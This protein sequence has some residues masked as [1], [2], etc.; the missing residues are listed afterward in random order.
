MPQ[1][2]RLAQ[3]WFLLLVLTLFAL[4]VIWPETAS[5]GPWDDL[6]K[7]AQ[8]MAAQAVKQALD[9]AE[10]SDGDLETAKQTSPVKESPPAVEKAEPTITSAPPAPTS[11]PPPAAATASSTPP[12]PAAAKPAVTTPAAGTAAAANPASGRNLTTVPYL[13]L[14]LKYQPAAVGDDQLLQLTQRQVDSDQR[15]YGQAAGVHSPVNKL[16]NARKDLQD[17]IQKLQQAET[18]G[19]KY[20]AQGNVDFFK[21]TVEKLERELAQSMRG[22]VFDRAEVENRDAAFA[23]QELASKYRRHL[24][25]LAAGLPDKYTL[26][27]RV[28]ARFYTYDFDHGI[29]YNH[30]NSWL[31]CNPDAGEPCLPKGS[32]TK[33]MGTHFFITGGNQA[34]WN[35][36][37]RLPEFKGYFV[38]R[39]P[40]APR[41]DPL[42]PNPYGYPITLHAG[43]VQAPSLVVLDRNIALPALKMDTASAEAIKGPPPLTKAEM[44]AGKVRIPDSQRLVRSILYLTIQDVPKQKTQLQIIKV[45]LDKLEIFSP[46][47]KLLLA[48]N[49]DD[50]ASSAELLAQAGAQE[51]AAA[52]GAKDAVAAQESRLDILG[53]K[54]GM[55]LAEAEAIVRA[56]MKPTSE[57]RYERDREF[58]PFG[59]EPF[60]RSTVYI[61]MEGTPTGDFQYWKT[62]TPKEVIGLTVETG[63]DGKDHVFGIYRF[64]NTPKNADLDAIGDSLRKKY[65]KPEFQQGYSAR[66]GNSKCQM[67]VKRSPGKGE[68]RAGKD[69]PDESGFWQRIYS[70][71]GTTQTRWKNLPKQNVFEHCGPGMSALWSER[72][73]EVSL[74]DLKAYF[75]RFEE[76]FI[77][78]SKNEKKAVELEL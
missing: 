51:A 2:K 49:A 8:D 19:A 20:T 77:V 26:E 69:I 27:F 21:Q 17:A 52:Q 59:A 56:R 24:E 35:K 63:A 23:A 53:I 18:Q 5:A 74:A 39:P 13:L 33:G 61:R 44:Q 68:L 57:F 12:A 71:I 45:G 70:S 28:P 75:S 9:D 3:P 78:G 32:K 47:Q 67:G 60:A 65:G 62:V 73:L 4:S 76:L 30:G 43:G 36:N 42:N 38:V 22:V 25:K 58:A 29:L 11:T 10:E 7:K 64:L 16:K 55:S 1:P 54:L 31:P 46:E 34:R 72:S 6:K 50:F 40:E 48:K 37:N 15:V 14:Q 41:A 66:W